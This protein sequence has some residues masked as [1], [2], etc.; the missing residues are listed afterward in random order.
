MKKIAFVVCAVSALAL[1]PTSFASTYSGA[2]VWSPKTAGDAGKMSFSLTGV[3]TDVD[4]QPVTPPTVNCVIQQGFE[5][6]QTLQIRGVNNNPTLP[7]SCTARLVD[8]SNNT[9]AS[10]TGSIPAATGNNAVGI[11]L[12]A[13]GIAKAQCSIPW[14]AP[15][16]VVSKLSLLNALSN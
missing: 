16:A 9:V 2:E 13:I 11:T 1:A 5:H 14:R 3:Q 10:G 15:G 6:V 12:G 8:T 7:I 4:T